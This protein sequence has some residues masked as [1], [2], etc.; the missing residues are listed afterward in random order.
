[1]SALADEVDE[2]G[3]PAFWQGM[4]GISSSSGGSFARLCASHA[5][6]VFAL[7]PSFPQTCGSLAL[8]VPLGPLSALPPFGAPS[9]P[10][11][12]GCTTVSHRKIHFAPS[13]PSSLPPPLPLGP[14]SSFDVVMSAFTLPP[15]VGGF[16][17]RL[18]LL[19]CPQLKLAPLFVF[20]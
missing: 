5:S 15:R 20:E 6:V 8:N 12:A 13:V 3:L 4:H 18:L 10:G 19:N 11:F 2:W 7:N 1:M 9:V 14:F 16:S 17:H